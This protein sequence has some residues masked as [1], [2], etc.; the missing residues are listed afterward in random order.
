MTQRLSLLLIL[1][2][3]LLFLTGLLMVYD[4][5]SAQL[6][7]KKSAM[8][9]Y[10]PF[11]KQLF[12]GVAGIGLGFW[13][14]RFG[15]TRFLELAPLLLVLS[16]I[17]LIAVFIPGIGLEI[18]GAKR[19]IGL[20]GGITFQ[21]SEFVKLVIPIYFIHA[22]LNAKSSSITLKHFIRTL[23]IISIPIALILL[24]PDNGT[25]GFILLTLL[26]L[27]FLT[28]VRWTYWVLPLTFLFLLGGIVA[29]NM[30]HVKSRITV[31]LHPELD[32]KGKGHQPFQSR[33]AAGSGKIVGRG[34]GESLQKLNYL[35][36]ARSDYIAAIFAEEFGFVGMIFLISLFMFL[37]YVGFS[38]AF[39][40]KDRAGFFL[41][42]TM[43]FLLAFQA[44]LNLG[45]VS[46]LLPSKGLTLPFFSQ[47][48][49]ALLGNFLCVFFLLSIAKEAFIEERR[50]FE[51]TI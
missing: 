28:K 33:I 25:T 3:T 12:Y 43:T 26:L 36:Q 37:I 44:F 23:A 39:Y 19:W 9:L 17:F 22:A 40:A 51:K 27:F 16:V 38:I 41:G 7:F 29:F 32:L 46:G 15:Y 50:K 5:T 2:T 20:M 31:Y 14:Y 48:G 45:V 42:A 24:E 18:N 47:G 30:P 21:P 13:V 11:V 1:T 35:P 49:T 4:T 34:L 8:S 10:E 6:L